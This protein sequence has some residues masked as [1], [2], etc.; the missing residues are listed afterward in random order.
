VS[1]AASAATESA[2]GEA[3]RRRLL[4]FLLVLLAL[5]VFIGSTYDDYGISWDEDFYADMGGAYLGSFFDMS[6]LTEPAELW[7]HLRT[8]GAVVDA[9]YAS[10]LSLLGGLGS[11]ETLHLV[12]AL[13][14]ALALV[15]VYRM[16]CGLSPNGLSPVA[17]ALLLVF[18][19][20][21]LGHIFDN[22]MDGSSTLLYALQMAFALA[23]LSWSAL[24]ER[25]TQRALL[26][27][28]CFG[29]LAGI[30]FSHRIPQLLVPVVYF[31]LLLWQARGRER[32]ARAGLAVGVFALGFFATLYA[33]D[34][35]VRLNPLTGAFERVLFAAN[36]EVVGRMLVLFDGEL[37]RAAGLPRYYLPQWMAISIPVPTLLLLGVGLIRLGRWLV[38]PEAANRRLEAVFLL[39]TL[40]V[41]ILA[42]V[43]TR[44]VIFDAWRHFLFLAIP[45]VVIAA[46]GLEEI[47]ERLGGRWR[48]GVAVVFLIVLATIGRGMARLHPYEYVYA[49]ALVGGLAG[50]DSRYEI[51]YWAKSH[52]E[53]A[54]WVGEQP[55]AD[56]ERKYRV[57]TCGPGQSV[58]YYLPESFVTTKHLAGAD[59]VVCVRRGGLAPI[60][61][62]ANRPHRWSVTRPPDHTVEREGVILTN[63]WNLA[64][65]P[66]GG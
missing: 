27:M 65:P 56:L 12:K 59:Y 38:V 53:A 13:F 17:G 3:V 4:L 19:P 48:W 22:H 62:I 46:L 55:R 42:V 49:N 35:Y 9:I 2:T 33:V 52:K 8:H 40:L 60:V 30:S 66:G 61:E 28:L 21:W 16:L 32:R 29:V 5:V 6:S 23:L 18:F 37:V 34:P 10:A 54:E 20:A 44:P 43:L 31:L 57:Y 24:F 39:A 50:I 25:G 45:I 51:D 36:A 11:F 14:S 63:I 7:R 15:P 26:R 58:A 64:D 41:P 1:A 47:T